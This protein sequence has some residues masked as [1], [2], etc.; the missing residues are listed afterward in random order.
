MNWT[1]FEPSGALSPGDLAVMAD[2]FGLGFGASGRLAADL[3]RRVRYAPVMKF[4]PVGDGGYAVHRMTYRGMG[5]WSWPL[6]HGALADVL[7]KY[8]R[9]IAT[10]RFFDLL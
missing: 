8:I 5:G 3:T 10:E 6:A 9:H 4:V 1:L 2:R 7:T